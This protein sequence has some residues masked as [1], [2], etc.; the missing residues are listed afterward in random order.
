MNFKDLRE[1]NLSK[2]QIKK[3]HDKADEMPKSDFIKRYGKD[4]DSVRFATATN[5][6]KKQLGIDEG[7]LGNL[8]KYF[9]G[10][11]PDVIGTKV[12]GNDTIPNIDVPVKTIELPIPGTTFKG[13][14]NGSKK[15]EAL[16]KEDEKSVGRVVKGLKKAV[17][18]HQGQVDALTKDI[19]DEVAPVTRAKAALDVAVAKKSVKAAAAVKQ[20]TKDK[21]DV[22][23][24]LDR[25]KRLRVVARRNEEVVDEANNPHQDVNNKSNSLSPGENKDINKQRQNQ[26]NKK[27][28]KAAALV[29]KFAQIER[30][31]KATA[32]ADPIKYKMDGD[33]SASKM[34]YTH[35]RSKAG[36]YAANV[37]PEYY[38]KKEEVK[39]TEGGP[40]S[41]PR[42]KEVTI[43]RNGKTKTVKGVAAK[44]FTDAGWKLKEEVEL[45]EVHFSNRGETPAPKGMHKLRSGRDIP[46]S[47]QVDK[48]HKKVVAM[49]DRNDHFGAKIEIAKACGDKKLVQIYNALELMHDKYGVV[50]NKSIELRQ[51]FEPVLNNAIDRKFGKYADVI[52]DA[53]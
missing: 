19:K 34:P 15:S 24:L 18:A 5:M 23:R 16:D 52:R 29:K 17:K 38:F 50:G 45:D 3:V 43:T 49:T 44:I 42:H 51:I 32:L 28:A 31:R 40:G 41:G 47:P 10:D 20:K 1:A 33:N 37:K 46:S 53:T 26:L 4:G 25:Q 22:Q 39:I 13:K 30:G 21:A 7:I 9:K 14:L 12:S 27:S 36:S 6:V 2:A 8:G 35:Y 48:I 11:R